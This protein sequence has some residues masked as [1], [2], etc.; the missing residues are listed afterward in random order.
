MAFGISGAIS[1]GAALA[2]VAWRRSVRS[3][4][5]AAGRRK[6]KSRSPV[7]SSRRSVLHRWGPL[8][9]DESQHHQLRELLIVVR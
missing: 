3:S 1:A 2:A 7:E 4:P 8:R 5:D 6:T 9:F